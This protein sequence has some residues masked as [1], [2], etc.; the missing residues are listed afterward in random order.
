MGAWTH[1]LLHL[2]EARN[3]RIASR[4]MYGAPAAGSSTRFNKRHKEVIDYVFDSSKDNQKRK[5]KN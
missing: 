2:P 4:R 5:K 3:M 1:L